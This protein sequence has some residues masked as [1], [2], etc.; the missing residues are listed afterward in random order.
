MLKNR[1]FGNFMKSNVPNSKEI[2]NEKS[3]RLKRSRFYD[4]IQSVRT[5]QSVF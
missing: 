2:E 3:A 5:L 1:T 4:K